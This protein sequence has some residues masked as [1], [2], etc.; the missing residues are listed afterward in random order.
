MNCLLMMIKETIKLEIERLKSFADID[1]NSI[2]VQ[3]C[4][5]FNKG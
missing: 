4:E 1:D 3:K 5:K 2:P